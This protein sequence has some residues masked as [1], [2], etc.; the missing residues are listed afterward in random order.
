MRQVAESSKT[1]EENSGYK[2][3]REQLDEIN[4]I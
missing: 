3:T 1:Y 2:P 4:R